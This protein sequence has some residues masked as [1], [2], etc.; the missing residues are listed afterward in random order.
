MTNSRKLEIFRQAMQWVLI[1]GFI[2]LLWIPTLDSFFDL[3]QA[4]VPNENRA[5][6]K[7]P[8][9]NSSLDGI[10]NYFSGLESYFNDHFGFRKQLIRWNHRWKHTFFNQ[11]SPSVVI[12]GRDGWLYYS[13][14]RMI[15]NYRGMSKFEPK[16][17]QEW[18]SLLESRRDWLAKRGI[19]YLFVIPPNKDSIYPEYLPDWITKVHPA[20]KLDQF[21]AYMKTNST[22]EVLDLRPVLLDAKTNCP[23]YLVTD[24]HWNFYGGFVAHQ[25]LIRT[26]SRQM[27]GLKPLSI[28]LFEKKLHDE[29]GGDLTR[30]L[31]SDQNMVETNCPSLA[32][33]PPLKSINSTIDLNL[34]PGRK[35]SKLTEPAITINP[36]AKGKVIIFRD[37]FSGT[38]VPF[39]GYYFNKVVYLWTYQWDP[40]FIE[41]EKPDL[42]IDE[43]LERFLYKENPGKTRALEALK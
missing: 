30:L 4:P 22:V 42:V 18:K 33:R 13:G 16:E 8:S 15:E 29:K 6:A 28:D 27:P 26:L 5:P 40:A 23:V 20:T 32:P 10:R 34:I 19:R 38:W 14:E 31:G 11:S 37:S 2:G 1:I 41:Q 25:E 36:D 3:D 21:V 35:W 7:Y 12:T 17:L 39:L 43:I 9:F 24:T